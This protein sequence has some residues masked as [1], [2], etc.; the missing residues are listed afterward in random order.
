MATG[1]AKKSNEIQLPGQNVTTEELANLNSFADAL[2]LVAEKIGEDKLGVAAQEIGDG[3]KLLENKDQLQ[4]VAFLAVAWD[5]HSGDHGEFVSVKVMTKDGTKYIIND[6]STGIYSQLL[7]YTQRKG[8]AGGLL[9]EKGLRRSDY[10]YTDDKG[11][12]KPAV[13]YYLDTSA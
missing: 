6:G 9:C 10:T 8:V 4:G 2:A 13:T 7:D 3:F 5:F 12:D 1:T 11:Q